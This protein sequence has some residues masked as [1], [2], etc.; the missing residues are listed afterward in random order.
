[1]LF[2]PLSFSAALH[3]RE[4]ER[5]FFLF[6]HIQSNKSPLPWLL[7]DHWPGPVWPARQ[8][9]YCRSAGVRYIVP[10]QHALSWA[11]K[12]A[13]WVTSGG[14]IT[15]S[16]G[17]VS[18]RPAVLTQITPTAAPYCNY[19]DMFSTFRVLCLVLLGT[20]WI[21]SEIWVIS[22]SPPVPSTPSSVTER[23][24]QEQPWS[25]CPSYRARSRL[26]CLVNY[27]QAAHSNMSACLSETDR[28]EGG[29][30]GG[31]D[32]MKVCLHV[33]GWRRWW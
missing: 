5:I 3:E 2:M 23:P 19:T 25:P 31:G 29:W 21:K 4:R 24:F 6:C 15:S 9:L 18:V 20:S 12:T 13:T 26:N 11:K 14:F 27:A 28:R 32:W 17:C 33:K 30:G 22:F 16:A 10:T 7:T 1:M 8:V